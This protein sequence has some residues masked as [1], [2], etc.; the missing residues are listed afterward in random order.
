MPS[1]YRI[2][3]PRLWRAPSVADWVFAAAVALFTVL[4]ARVWWLSKLLPGQDYTQFLVFVR[5]VRD[6]GD[7]ASPFHGTYTTGPW[8]V[9]TSLPVHL[10]NLLSYLCGGSIESGGKL[11]LTLRDAGLVAAAI[12][13]LKQLGRPRW[14]VALIFPLLDGPWSIV[15]G[16]ASFDTAF[17]LVVLGWALIVRW[18]DRLDVGSAIALAAALCLTLLWHGI[19]YVQLGLAFA[20]LWLLWRA[21]SFGARLLAVVPCV[22]SLLQYALWV[23]STFGSHA[24]SAHTLWATPLA[25]AESILDVVWVQVPERTVQALFLACVVG[26]GLLA[27]SGNIGAIGRPSRMWI[28]RNP[29]VIVA[30][31]Y[32]LGYFVLPLYVGG[33]AGFSNRFAYPAALALVFGWNL[34]RGRAARGLVVVGVLGL[35]AWLLTDLA[36]RFRAF[37]SRTDGASELLD[38]MGPRETLYYYPGPDAGSAPEFYSPNK[39]LQEL[40]QFATARHGGLPN[41][42]FAGYGYTYVRYVNGQ[43]PMPGLT[44]PPVWS[45]AMTRFDYVLVRGTN[46]LGDRR[47]PKIDS[48]PGWELHG[49]C[50]SHRFPTCT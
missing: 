35:S 17:P 12:Y 21:P 41:S 28:V 36:D 14:A 11:L 15:G 34:P 44:G 23:R 43:N 16:F 6:L 22:P 48:R 32:L 49:V 24:P 46:A 10:T 47:F 18:F 39:A 4:A 30:A 2:R 25:A 42:S 27:G 31:A 8:F 19:A 29:F 45:P 38:R 9:P 20:V 3:W 7:P 40:Q 26:F 5:A 1:A 37:A 50:G 13:L 33:V